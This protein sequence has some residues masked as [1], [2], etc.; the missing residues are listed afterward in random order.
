MDRSE[1]EESNRT[2]Q[3]LDAAVRQARGNIRQPFG[4]HPESKILVFPYR[5]RLEADLEGAG[6][7]W[8]PNI[9]GT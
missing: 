6:E 2:N 4:K 9:P 7:C 1:T 5:T 3:M 8:R